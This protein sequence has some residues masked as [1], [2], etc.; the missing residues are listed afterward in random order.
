MFVK[1]NFSDLGVICMANAGGNP[2]STGELNIVTH[3][4]DEHEVPVTTPQATGYSTADLGYTNGFFF[5]ANNL[6]FTL[7]HFSKIYIFEKSQK[8]HEYKS[9]RHFTNPGHLY[10][11]IDIRCDR[12]SHTNSLFATNTDDKFHL[13]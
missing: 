9:D 8:L 10:D 6:A 3:E 4:A 7:Y 12:Q 13:P 11:L 5:E 1:V 2:P